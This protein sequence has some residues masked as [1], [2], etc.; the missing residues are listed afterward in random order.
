MQARLG[1]GWAVT[2]GERLHPR[3]KEAPITQRELKPEK[4]EQGERWVLGRSPRGQLELWLL[5]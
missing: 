4:G 1:D 3:P 5:V 2:V